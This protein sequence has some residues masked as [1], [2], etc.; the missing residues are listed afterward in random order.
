M[1]DW[2]AGTLTVMGVKRL[3]GVTI[4]GSLADYAVAPATSLARIPDQLSF[5]EAATLPI[6]ATT[7]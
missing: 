7:A 1:V 2:P 3:R 5:V 4:P 6:A